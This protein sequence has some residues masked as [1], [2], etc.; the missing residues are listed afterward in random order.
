V[1]AM[2]NCPRGDIRSRVNAELAEDVLDVRARRTRAD[3]QL[4]SKLSIR[5]SLC[6]QLHDFALPRGKRV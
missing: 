2:L 6:H 4:L 5:S 1:E 3:H